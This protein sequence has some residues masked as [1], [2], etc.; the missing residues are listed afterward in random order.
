MAGGA[1]TRGADARRGDWRAARRSGGTEREGYLERSAAGDVPAASA[2]LAG[3]AFGA[4]TLVT[5]LGHGGMGSVWLARPQR[6]PLR[7][8]GR[9]K[10]LNAALVGRAAARSASRARAR[11]LARLAHPHIARLLDAGVSPAGQPYLVARSTSTGER[12]DRYCDARRSDVDVA[13]APVSRRARG[14]RARARQPDRASRHQAVQRPR[15]ARRTASSCSTSAS[16]SCSKTK[17]GIG[18]RP[19]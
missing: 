9:V 11:I 12:I 13:S 8:H 16:P 6:R 14:G 4:Y 3:Q 15:R 1:C 17:R 10:L 2:S 19:S 5:P 18:R 7:R